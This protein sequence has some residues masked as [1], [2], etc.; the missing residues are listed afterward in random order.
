MSRS[1]T[2]SALIVIDMGNVFISAESA[3]CIRNAQLPSQRS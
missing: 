3:L 2:R 1:T